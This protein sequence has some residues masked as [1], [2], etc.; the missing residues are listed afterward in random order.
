MSMQVD[1]HFKKEQIGTLFVWLGA[2]KGGWGWVIPERRPPQKV[3]MPS[4]KELLYSTYII[5]QGCYIW[6]LHDTLHIYHIK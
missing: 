6:R 5:F 3:D 1:A 4:I 2:W